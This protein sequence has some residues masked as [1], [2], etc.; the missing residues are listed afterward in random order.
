MPTLEYAEVP[1][2]LLPPGRIDIPT[3]HARWASG[4]RIVME[5]NFVGTT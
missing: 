5:I 4:S 2:I 3:L 1:G